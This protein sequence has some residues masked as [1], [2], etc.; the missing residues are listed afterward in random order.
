MTAIKEKCVRIVQFSVIFY[1]NV[2]FLRTSDKILKIHYFLQYNNMKKIKQSSVSEFICFI[3]ENVT[4]QIYVLLNIPFL[5]R[6]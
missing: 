5:R 1:M 2:G 3:V 4:P 6:G